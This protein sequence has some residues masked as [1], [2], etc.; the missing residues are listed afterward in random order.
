MLGRFELFGVVALQ[1]EQLVERVE[2]LALD[3]RALVDLRGV[4]DGIRQRV[5]A[6]RAFVAVRHRVA[7]E[8]L[9]RIEQHKI[10]APGV[11][12]ERFRLEACLACGSKSCHHFVKEHLD[13]PA[14]VTVDAFLDVVEAVN[15]GELDVAGFVDPADNH[16]PR[17]C[18][19]IDGGV[20]VRVQGRFH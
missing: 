5:D 15:F 16:A 17:R 6:L 14:I 18:S 8:L 20:T 19:D 10:H 4:H 1:G 11:D 2:R 9:L 13:V 12:A 3:A 7:D